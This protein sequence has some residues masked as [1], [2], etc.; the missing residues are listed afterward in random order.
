[1]TTTKTGK[2]KQPK[3][4]AT[5]KFSKKRGKAP[6][7][8]TYVGTREKQV[9]EVQIVAYNEQEQRSY[10]PHTLEEII[11]FKKSGHI[12]W[13]DIAGLSD[14][15][16]IEQLGKQLN[17]NPLI[18]EDTVNVNQRPKIDE[19][20]DY[21]FGV[22]KMLYLDKNDKI[23]TEHMAMV[24]VEDAVLVFQEEPLDDVFD[25]VRERIRTKTGRVR[26]AGADYL[27]FALLDAIVDNY[28]IILESI[29]E[30]IEG[31]EEE[32]Y[33]NPVPDVAK[34]IQALKKEVMRL[35]RLIFPVREMIV[36]LI[37][38]ENPL[39][40][41]ETK[42]FLRDV[43]DHATEINETLQIYR[44]MSMSLMEMYMS[45]MSNKMNEVMKVLTIMASIF[46]PLTFIAGIYGMNFDHMPELHTENG[47]FVV[48]GVMISLFVGMLFYFKRKGWL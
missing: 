1:M 10:K 22:F 37:E 47:Y 5:S 13:I 7:T 21:I 44:E 46:I 27:F 17:L 29:Q 35:R 42:L 16:Y 9:A 43:L 39:I 6:G 28:F 24:L 15:Q 48:W 8:V 26:F 36:R 11:N 33:D 31:L 20:D 38:T 40:K 19:Y 18:L 25:G 34:R 23:V 12:S 45:N 41:K 3:A 2:K 14:E 4:K 30:Q 32:V